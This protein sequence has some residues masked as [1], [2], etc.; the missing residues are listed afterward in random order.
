MSQAHEP[1]IRERLLNSDAIAQARGLADRAAL[2]QVAGEL[3]QAIA[4]Q[5]QALAIASAHMPGD[6]L[7][8]SMLTSLGR[9]HEALGNP[10]GAVA[11]H[12]QALGF[13]RSALGED[14]P[15]TAA[16]MSNIGYVLLALG[17]PEATRPYYEQALAIRMRAL[18]PA[19]TD[20]GLSLYNMACLLQTLGD[21]DGARAHCAQALTICAANLG[22]GHPATQMIQTTIA[23]LGG[24]AGPASMQQ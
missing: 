3:D 23:S 13:L 10:A 8:A 11:H 12:R 17:D 5:E 15:D 19:H 22:E 21:L 7:V 20:T 14:H 4:L 6:P 2:M 16:S 24:L 18:G 1:T 9:M